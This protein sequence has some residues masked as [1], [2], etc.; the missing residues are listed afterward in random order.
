MAKKRI[1]KNTWDNWN[2]YEGSKRVKEFGLDEQAA[3][4]WL[5]ALPASV[6]RD[7]RVWTVE[8]PDADTVRLVRFAIDGHGIADIMEMARSRFDY[9]LQKG[10]VKVNG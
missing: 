10:W 6:V 8:S 5:S 7:E 3:K 9:E 1:H 2:G 4:D